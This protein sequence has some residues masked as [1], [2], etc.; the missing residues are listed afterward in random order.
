VPSEGES[1]L[2]IGQTEVIQEEQR[3][4]SNTPANERCER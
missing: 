4:E 3:R 1:G 2:A